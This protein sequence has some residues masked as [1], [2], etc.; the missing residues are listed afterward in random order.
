M[1]GASL[2]AAA[3]MSLLTYKRRYS[4]QAFVNSVHNFRLE[5]MFPVEKWLYFKIYGVLN[6]IGRKEF[7]SD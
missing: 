5:N 6:R 1:F 3:A 4:I 7:D 2:T